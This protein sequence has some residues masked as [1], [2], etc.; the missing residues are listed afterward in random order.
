MKRITSLH[1]SIL[2]VCGALLALTGCDSTGS[3]G[4]QNQPPTADV[5]VSRS[6]VDVGT[7]VT[8]DGSG[9]SDPDGDD[10][11]YSWSL[12]TPSGSSASLSDPS[13][14][15]PTFT[16]DVA[17]DYVFTL[18]VSDGDA[19]RSGSA[20]VTAQSSTIELQGTISSD[21]TLTA[22][23]DYLVTSGVTVSDG[24]TLTIEPGTHLPFES[25]AGLY[26][27]PNSVL[28]AN[29]T[30]SDPITMTAT[31]GNE[32][33][34]WWQGVFFFSAEPNNLLNHVEIRHTGSGSPNSIGDA[35]V[36]LAGGSALSI[37]N[38]TIAQS[39]AFGLLLGEDT[40]TLDDF[41]SNTFADNADAPVYI[42]FTSIGA[43][44]AASSFPDGKTVRVWGTSLEGS[45]VTVS[46]L[47][48]DTPYRFTDG[49]SA[50]G[51]ATSGPSTLTVEAGVEMA[52]A[53]GIRLQVN[54]GSVL[55][56]EGTAQDPITLTATAGNEEQGWWDGVYVFSEN[57]NSRL[58]HVEIR[59][60]GGGSPGTIKE[61]AN[62]GLYQNAVLEVTQSAITDSGTHGVYCDDPSSA[63]TG[64]SN[65]YQNNAGQNTKGCS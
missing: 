58:E 14:E 11:I 24:A 32:Q 31:E 38:S 20:T 48:G 33:P 15:Q 21:S 64:S 54:G 1:L 23:Q 55:S 26:I 39:E 65:T 42:P 52:F 43:I 17:G 51:G 9:S 45:D 44:D 49:N 62:I 46:I 60:G 30:S 10:L 7:Q 12:D 57:T 41:A 18:E 16:P 6:T 19:S 56:A 27:D 37:K 13:V 61:A 29:G 34:G 59:H 25:G 2:V 47:A 40:A 53:S 3:N 50:I 36:A 63:F 5:S 8:L 22:A 4:S 28:D 35:G